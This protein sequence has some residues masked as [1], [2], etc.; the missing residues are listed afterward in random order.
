MRAL[1][2]LLV[3]ALLATAAAP[4][5]VL[6]QSQ[7]PGPALAGDDQPRLGI[8]VHELDATRA[9]PAAFGAVRLWDSGTAWR[10][11][12]PRP[13]AWDFERLDARVALAAARGQRLLLTLG[14]TPEWASSRPQERCSYG[15]GCAAP[16]ARLSDWQHYVDTVSRRY[17]GRIECYEI[18]NEVRFQQGED[19]AD[20]GGPPMFYSGTLAQLLE[21]SRE[22]A[23]IIRRNDPAACLLS[24]SFHNASPNWVRNLE[25][26]LA[27][28]GRGLIDGISFHFYGRT[29]EET[30]GAVRAVRRVMAAQGLADRPLWNTEFGFDRPR[31]VATDGAGADAGAAPADRTV[32]RLAALV[33]RSVVLAASENVAR[34]YWYAFDN[35]KMGIFHDELAAAPRFGQAMSEL[36]DALSTLR[37]DGCGPLAGALWRCAVRGS[38]GRSGQ[39]LWSAA[40]GFA[41]ACVSRRLLGGAFVASGAPGA[42]GASDASRMLMPALREA[43]DVAA[44]PTPAGHD[45]DTV[46]VGPAPLLLFPALPAPRPATS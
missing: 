45:G 34:H 19:P 22:A 43:G 25:R 14:S 5:P 12:E 46:C 33:A 37:F 30:L 44:P 2:S 7:T 40:P 11:L 39:V 6:A 13:G 24:P 41:Q 4:A 27:D 32:A 10:R 16:P 9:R 42:P 36:A 15:L 23:R 26:Y 18:W 28:G 8:H 20:P 29:P 3:A 31:F 17:R 38:A 1:R 21:L 35:R